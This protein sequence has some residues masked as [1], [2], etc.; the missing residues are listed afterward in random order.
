MTSDQ[1]KK[2]GEQISGMMWEHF[3]DL[4]YLFPSGRVEQHFKI[5]AVGLQEKIED[6]AEDVVA[7]GK[8]ETL[9][10][11]RDYQSLYNS[12]FEKVYD[13]SYTPNDKDYFVL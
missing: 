2:E 9:Q 1:L 3:G 7:S 4:Y 11:Y 12:L 13:L 8:R 10:K 5:T 6:L